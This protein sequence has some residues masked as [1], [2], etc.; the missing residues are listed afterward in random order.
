M[1]TQDLLCQNNL[2]VD[3][4]NFLLFA[5]PRF[6]FNDVLVEVRA[7]EGILTPRDKEGSGFPA[8]PSEGVG[9]S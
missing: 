6:R 3:T 7:T 8:T 4:F 9:C 5:V 1:S 2:L